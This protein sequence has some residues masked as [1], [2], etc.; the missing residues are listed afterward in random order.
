MSTTSTTNN[1]QVWLITGASTGIG[2]SIVQKV[3]ESGNLVVGLTRSPDEL[4]KSIDSNKLVN[5]FAFKTDITS[6]ASVKEAIE[7][8]I[9]KF[10]RIDIVVNNAG[11]GYLGALEESSIDDFKQIFEVNFF[12]VLNIVKYVSPYLRNQKSGLIFNISSM[13]GSV[14]LF[15]SLASYT[16]SKF[17]LNGLTN[18]LDIDLKPFGV[19]CIVIS[20]GG[21]KSKFISSNL[22]VVKNPIPE[23]KTSDCIAMF[24]QYE[25]HQPGDPDK[26][27]LALIELSKKDWTALPSNIFLGTDAYKT[28]KNN[29]EKLTKELEDYKSLTFSTDI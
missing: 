12:A 17:A 7:L 20:P 27:A 26:A 16:S 9:Q 6:E 11:Y 14:A 21:F 24:N 29:I 28:M 23:Y 4:T 13:V 22:K 1:K 2:L 25:G 5:L 19:R 10:G 18:S 15:P 8:S 3:L